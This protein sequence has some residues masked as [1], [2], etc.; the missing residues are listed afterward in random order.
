MKFILHDWSDKQC[1]QILGHICDAMKA[2]YSKLIIEEFI[3]PEKDCPM[4]SAMW[5]W[6]MMVF[7]NS[8]ERSEGHW[9]R[10]L[11]EAGFEAKFW[12]PPGD[13]Q[14]CLRPLIEIKTYV[15]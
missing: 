4:L 2:G 6:E 1:L 14:V 9:S 13:G 3:L 11:N 8:L 12:Y 15:D 7:C 10:L 5:D